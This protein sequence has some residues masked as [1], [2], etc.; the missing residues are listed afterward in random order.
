MHAELNAKHHN[1]SVSDY[2]D[3]EIQ[4]NYCLVKEAN[5]LLGGGFC[6]VMIIN[7]T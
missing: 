4:I 2:I 6:P 7:F 5:V 1:C 3:C